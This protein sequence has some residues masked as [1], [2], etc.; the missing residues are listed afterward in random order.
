M[1]VG[2]KKVRYRNEDK[3]TIYSQYSESR[4]QTWLES[5]RRQDE[6]DQKL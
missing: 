3:N 4:N 2:I 5:V 6:L 1:R